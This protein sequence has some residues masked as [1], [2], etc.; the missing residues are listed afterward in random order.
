M[1]IAISLPYFPGYGTG[2]GNA[3]K[4]LANGLISAGCN[5]DVLTEKKFSKINY[6]DDLKKNLES[7]IVRKKLYKDLQILLNLKVKS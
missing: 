1:K 7:T 2:T 4:N 6:Q 5:I 3:I